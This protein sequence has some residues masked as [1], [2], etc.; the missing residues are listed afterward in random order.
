MRATAGDSIRVA[1][2][3]TAPGETV[4]PLSAQSLAETGVDITAARPR[5]ATAELLADADVVVTP[6]L[7]GPHLS[8][9]GHRCRGAGAG[10]RGSTARAGRD[11][12]RGERYQAGQHEQG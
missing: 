3:G 12:P 8:G 4:N 2:A 1:S 10:P 5:P 11:C 9:A 6:G 7:R